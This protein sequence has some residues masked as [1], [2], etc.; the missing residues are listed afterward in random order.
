MTWLVYVR[1]E[2]ER[3]LANARDWYEKKQAGL[4]AEFLD[5]VAATIRELESAPERPRLYYRN[6]R[7][8]L[9]RRFPYKLFYQ[10]I[11]SRVLVFRVL[12]AKQEH[13]RSLLNT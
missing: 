10:V 13:G 12:H 4:G 6:F 5:E 7:R 9:L 3:D 1:P 8:M 2:A 11:D